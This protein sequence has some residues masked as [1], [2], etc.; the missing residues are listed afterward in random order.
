[1][2][3]GLRVLAAAGALLVGCVGGASDAPTQ[4]CPESIGA[5]CDQATPA[6]RPGSPTPYRLGILPESPI[7]DVPAGVPVVL[8]SMAPSRRA[9]RGDDPERQGVDHEAL[10]PS[11]LRRH[12]IDPPPWST[13][14]THRTTGS[15]LLV[16][17]RTGEEIARVIIA[18]GPSPHELILQYATGRFVIDRYTGETI[19]RFPLD[20]VSILPTVDVL[21]ARTPMD[22]I[23]DEILASIRPPE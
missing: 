14:I 19:A 5:D 2:R 13:A 22:A 10:V 20:R 18:A 4:P 6:D 7:F 16:D 1:M 17:N 9:I 15:S 11:P 21:F 3:Q 23:F 8:F 12:R